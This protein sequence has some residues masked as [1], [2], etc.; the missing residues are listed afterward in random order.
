M[1]A[2][3]TYLE[4]CIVRYC[5]PTLAKLKPAGLFSCALTDAPTLA[6][7]IDSLNKLLNHQDVHLRVLEATAER[8][9]IYVYRA[10]PLAEHLAPAA[11]QAFLAECGYRPGSVEET[12][13]QLQAKLAAGLPHEIGLFLGYPLA[14]VIGF[15]N[16]KGQNY[17]CC[18]CWKVYA[19]AAQAQATFG[20]LRRCRGAYLQQF[21]RGKSLPE[22]VRC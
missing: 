2:S 12:L 19:D 10:E 17:L 4:S 21:S 18:G 11:V 3:R 20:E 1:P 9:L 5:A 6:A 7:Q 8:A 15:I 16:N 22:L 14:D 13:R